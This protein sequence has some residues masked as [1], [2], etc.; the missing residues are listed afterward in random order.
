M[1]HFKVNS[2]I[3]LIYLVEQKGINMM[4]IEITSLKGHG[5]KLENLIVSIFKEDLKW[6]IYENEVI[7][8]NQQ[9]E[10]PACVSSAELIGLLFGETTV[11]VSLNIQA[12]EKDTY[13][14]TRPQ[15]YAG[16]VHSSCQAIILIS[17][18]DLLEIYAKDKNLLSS[19]LKKYAGNENYQIAIKKENKDDRTKLSV[20]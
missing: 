13:K 2:E 1:S 20:I 5:F 9:M 17:D 6:Y 8:N 12:Y 11:I 10:L 7:H 3:L 14:P 15:T 4:G 19:I 18:G 16:F